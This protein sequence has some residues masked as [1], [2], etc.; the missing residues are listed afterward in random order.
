M[1]Y[2]SAL[3]ASRNVNYK[4]EPQELAVAHR[5]RLGWASHLTFLLE[6][7]SRRLSRILYIKCIRG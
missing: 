2:L 1:Y 3:T 6:H 4:E 5:V 7:K